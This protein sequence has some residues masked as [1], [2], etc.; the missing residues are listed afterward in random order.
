MGQK[1]KKKAEK[2]NQNKINLFKCISEY[3]EKGNL[4]KS[5]SKI[6]ELYNFFFKNKDFYIFQNMIKEDKNYTDFIIKNKYIDKNYIISLLENFTIDEEIKGKEYILSFKSSNGLE[7]WNVNNDED[8]IDNIKYNDSKNKIEIKIV[9]KPFEITEPN[10]TKQINKE[11][12]ILKSIIQ[13]MNFM[14]LV[15]L[16]EQKKQSTDMATS[17]TKDMATSETKDMATSETKDEIDIYLH[18]GIKI[19]I[20]ENEYIITAPIDIKNVNVDT[21][22][23][24]FLAFCFIKKADKKKKLQRT[25]ENFKEL[26]N[27][28]NE[29]GNDNENIK[30]KIITKNQKLQELKKQLHKYR[31]TLN[32]QTKPQQNPLE[33]PPLEIHPKKLLEWAIKKKNEPDD[34]WWKQYPNEQEIFRTKYHNSIYL[35]YYQLEEQEADKQ[36]D[37]SLYHKLLYLNY[38]YYKT[39]YGDELKDKIE[40]GEIIVNNEIFEIDAIMFKNELKKLKKKKKEK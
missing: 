2:E 17:E 28:N 9:E 29:K 26:I 3:G 11:P 13:K 32:Q 16:N 1:K 18:K 27:S 12:K 23:G 19:K 24:L 5:A 31:D 37:W 6:K 20:I 21:N 8:M 15:W 40:S 39:I 14:F 34:S 4:V 35:Y 7:W 22:Y 30:I 38:I 25:N 10:I 33:I 36:Y